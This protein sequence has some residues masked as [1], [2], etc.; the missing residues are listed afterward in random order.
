MQINI[1]YYPHRERVFVWGV[2]GPRATEY[3]LKVINTDIRAVNKAL[4]AIYE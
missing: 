2:Y 3:M 1:K 4:G